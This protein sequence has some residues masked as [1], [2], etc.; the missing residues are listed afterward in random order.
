MGTAGGGAGCAEGGPEREKKTQ[1]RAFAHTPRR[2]IKH[3]HTHTH[4]ERAGPTYEQTASA[5][6][7]AP[8]FKSRRKHAV[9]AM[10]PRDARNRFKSG[11]VCKHSRLWFK[12]VRFCSVQLLTPSFN[13]DTSRN[14]EDFILPAG[15]AVFSKTMSR[16]E[17]AEQCEICNE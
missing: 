4:T 14:N 17:G 12:C 5:D 10:T 6:Y 9:T 3:I 1:R 16:G 13:C 11:D 2:P 7:R 15:A 8:L